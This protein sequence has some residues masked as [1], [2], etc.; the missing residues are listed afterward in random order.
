MS[1]LHWAMGT[2]GLYQESS[3]SPEGVDQ[4]SIQSSSYI[5]VYVF[6]TYFL[7]EFNGMSIRWLD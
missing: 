4:E 7:Y 5:Y 6:W 1:T 2:V 3:Y